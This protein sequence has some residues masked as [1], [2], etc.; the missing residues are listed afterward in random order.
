MTL[1]GADTLT[2]RDSGSSN[3]ELIFL[4]N[5]NGRET[6]LACR[7]QGCQMVYFQTK[8]SKIWVNFGGSCNGRIC[9]II[10]SLWQILR[11]FG[12]FL[13]IRYIFWL[14]GIF[15]GYLVYF[16]VIWYIF[17]LFGIFSG[18]LVYLLVIWYI[19]YLFGIFSGYLVYFLVI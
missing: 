13:T 3:L 16:L 17:W 1:A 11:P 9:Y 4:A 19:F 15:Y 8:K 12:I 14:F 5:K 6:C 18:Y 7:K 2:A 10:M